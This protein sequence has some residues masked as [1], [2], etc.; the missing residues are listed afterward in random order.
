MG[1]V[2]QGDAAQI[3]IHSTVVARSEEGDQLAT[4]VSLPSRHVARHL[5]GANHEGQLVGDQERVGHVRAKHDGPR[6]SFSWAASEVVGRV[7][8][9]KVMKHLGLLRL[10]KHV[11]HPA[12]QVSDC[13]KWQARDA[14]EAAVDHEHVAGEERR[15]REHL[16]QPEE[17]LEQGGRVL[18]VHFVC[19]AVVDVLRLGLVVAAV[20]DDVGWV[21]DLV[22]Q[23]QHKDFDRVLAPVSNVPVDEIRRGLG[24]LAVLFEHKQHVL[25][26]P[27]RVAQHHHLPV[28]RTWDAHVG[29][30]VGQRLEELHRLAENLCHEALVKRHVRP[31]THVTHNLVYV[32]EG[33]RPLDFRA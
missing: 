5:M 22:Q 25:Q 18:A 15:D 33:E 26:L 14:R 8:P 7:R 29:H 13:G 20:D 11:L 16:V 17:H 10:R 23:Q 2:E 3:I 27:V 28:R 1:V 32:V 12:V 30:R 31:R 6:A 21:E 4:V 9:Q 19:E 24:G